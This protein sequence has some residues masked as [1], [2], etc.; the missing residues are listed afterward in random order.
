VLNTLADVAEEGE[1]VLCV[2]VWTENQTITEIV[3]VITGT[4][5]TNPVGQGPF[6]QAGT[7]VVDPG[8]A[9]TIVQQAIDASP[10]MKVGEASTAYVGQSGVCYIGSSFTVT[11]DGNGVPY[12]QLLAPLMQIASG[13]NLGTGPILAF[14]DYGDVGESGS[15]LASQ[16]SIA[17]Q[18]NWLNGLDSLGPETPNFQQYFAPLLGTDQSVNQAQG[19]AAAAGQ[20]VAS[21]IVTGATALAGLL[22]LIIVLS[23]VNALPRGNK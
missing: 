23:I 16:A 21:A 5:D 4:P 1:T 20:K 10:G 11:A 19:A 2:W 15:T 14:V 6:G 7:S 3:D 12:L 18:G 9:A 13:F 8:T 22:T 17:D